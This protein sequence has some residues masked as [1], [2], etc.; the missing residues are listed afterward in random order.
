MVD[1]PVSDSKLSAMRLLVTG[2]A[3][4]I[5]SHFVRLVLASRPGDSVVSLDALTYSGNLSTVAQFDGNPRFRFAPGRIEDPTVVRGLIEAHQITHIVNFAAESHNDRSLIEPTV[6]L[7][8][9][10]MGIENLLQVAR[11]LG[12]QRILHVSTDEVYGSIPSGKFSEDSPLEPNTPY[13]ASKAAGDL[14]CRAHWITYRTPVVVTRGGNT[15]G[16]YQYPEKLIPFF[17]TRLLQG[18]KVPVYGDG[19]QIREW[20]HASDHSAGILRALLQGENGQIYNVGDRNEH[21]N[22]DI[23][24][25]LLEETG[26]DA[27]L[28]KHIPDPRGAAH[29]ARYSMVTDKI[30]GLGWQP[31]VSFEEGLRQT[32]KWYAENEAWWRPITQTSDYQNFVKRYYGPS[33][34][35]D[36]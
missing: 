18:K 32:V 21:R 5:G 36:L 6:F 33:L 8:S 27:S 19:S 7:R 31:S 20:I 24:K 30:Q 25:I 3:G 10:A 9:N 34:G 22:M 26:R 12:V 13:S 1:L 2:S 23:V 16:P 11:E 4:F 28:V 17:T 14:V 35:P 15:Y 29:D